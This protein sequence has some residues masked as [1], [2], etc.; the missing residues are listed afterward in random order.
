MS[1]HIAILIEGRTEQVFLPVLRDFLKPRLEGRM[2]KLDPLPCD[3]RIPKET[4]LRR[5]VRNL[6]RD[7][8]D[9]VV[10]LTDVYTGTHDFHDAADAK[11]K[12]KAWVGQ[13]PRFHPHVA[14]YDFEAWLLPFWSD[15][16][17]L[18]G[19]N[20]QAPGAHPESINHNNP[21][22]HILRDIFRTGTKLRSYVKPRDALRILRGN[23][24]A[25]AA[26]ACPELK[27]FINT[28]LKASG[29][30]QL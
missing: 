27:A 30:H 22:A 7:G 3:G 21:P 6:L 26:H 14:L 1:V 11:A 5:R 15:I 19:S 29:G 10:A 24:L 4:E 18:S 25:V 28:I 12:M 2:P 13:E 9:L 20:R 16:Q 8:A 17:R 23:D